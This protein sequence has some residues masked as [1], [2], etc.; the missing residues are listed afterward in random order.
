MILY[1]DKTEVF[2]CNVTVEGAEISDTKSRLIIESNKWNLVFYGDVDK[3][4]KCKI[5]IENLSILKE[6]EIGKIRLEIISE[7]T[8]FTPW[9]D[10][11]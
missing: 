4:G 10:N 3:S 2:E 7:S 9:S 8:V 11:C 6:G 1:T 5:N